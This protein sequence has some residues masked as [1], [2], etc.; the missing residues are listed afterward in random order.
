MRLKL[1]TFIL[2]MLSGTL[3]KSQDSISIKDAGDIQFKAEKL[4][5]ELNDLLVILSANDMETKEKDEIIAN[6][7]SG[8]A[9]RIFTDSSVLVEDDTNPMF[10]KS[11]QS[12]D[13]TVPIYLHDFDLFYSKSDDR[14]VDLNNVKSSKVKKSKNVYVK[15]YFTSLFKNKSSSDGT[16][17]PT[18]RVAEIIATKENNK[19][20]VLISRLGFFSPADTVHDVLNDLR[21]FYVNKSLSTNPRDSAAAVTAQRSFEEQLTA[22]RRQKDADEERIKQERVN[23][24]LNKSDKALEE[25]D[26]TGALKYLTDAKEIDQFNPTIRGAIT[27]VR[28]QESMSK[29]ST[30]QMYDRLIQKAKLEENNR[31]YENAL[32]DYKQAFSIKPEEQPAYDIHLKELTVKFRTIS[33]EEDKYKA[34]LYKEA[35]KD[36]EKAIKKDNN[37]SDYYFGIGKCYDKL[38]D[39]SKALKYYTQAYVL[40]NNNLGAIKYRAELY[41]RNNEY[42]KALTDYKTYLTIDKSNTEVYERISALHVLLNQNKEAIE[43]LNKAIDANP[44]VSHLY[45][46]KGILLYQNRDYKQA[47]ENFTN[48]IQLD[49]ANANAYFQRGKCMMLRN[50]IRSAASDFDRARANKLDEQ[51]T[52][53][54]DAYAEAVYQR[55]AS[56][57]SNRKM[58]SALVLIDQAI[59]FNPLS[60]LYRFERGEYYYFIK[61]NQEAI[62]SYNEAVRLNDAYGEAY[63][64]RGCAYFNLGNYPAAV[65][66]FNSAL[67]INPQY[68]LAQKGLADSY[69]AAASYPESISAM[70]TCIKMITTSKTSFSQDTQSEIYNTLGK[71]YFE[72]SMYDKAL[73]AFKLSLKYNKDNAEALYYRGYTY[74][75]TS[76][77]SGAI[78][79]VGKSLQLQPGHKERNFLMGE[80]YSSKK[81]YDNAARYFGYCIRLD[82]AVSIPDAIYLQG[83]SNYEMH[84][85]TAALP[86]YTRCTELKIDSSKPSFNSELGNIYLNMHKYDSS[87]FYFNKALSRNAGDGIACY[88]I[89]TTLLLQGK[90]EESFVWFEK[91]FSVKEPTYAEI[92]KDKLIENI[93][94]DK[95]FKQLLKKYY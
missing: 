62:F 67:K 17:T 45:L 50:D 90:K 61:N 93:R 6:S 8:S 5:K 81:D 34:G 40:D 16:Y 85:Y 87:Y 49:S 78:E 19:W 10:I 25:N 65:E 12:K 41:E 68:I 70:E 56:N 32:T 9:N 39:A 7:Y 72:T 15:V 36:Y 26:F 55:A 33:E 57:F 89:A 64:R 38:G 20:N 66:N 91:S 86:N 13:E 11:G 48:A 27:R 44:K 3:C 94:D 82:S 73:A 63:Y 95:R 1:T 75:K 22:E 51:D 92:K 23:Q 54:I 24:L 4:V 35:I 79:D 30:S 88:G 43:D 74:Y 42:F 29:I 46:S 84:N 37:N 18:N 83:Y 76:Q 47:A 53:S 28:N 77:P 80:I 60:P 21:I 2:L 69:F 59:L 71:D 31:L 52:K 14:S 58:D